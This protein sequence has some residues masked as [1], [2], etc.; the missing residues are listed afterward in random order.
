MRA[1]R[2]LVWTQVSQ[3]HKVT[4]NTLID[5]SVKQKGDEAPTLTPPRVKTI[6]LD[7]YKTVIKL[8]AEVPHKLP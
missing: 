2:V 3:D 4:S 1:G 5:H 8:C 6:N 7:S